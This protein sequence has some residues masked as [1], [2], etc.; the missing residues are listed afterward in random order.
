M[1]TSDKL[2]IY[3]KYDGNIDMFARVGYKRH[4]N[5]I[6]DKEWYIIDELVSRVSNIKSGSASEHYI[7]E[8]DKK[9]KDNLDCEE[10]VKRLKAYCDPEAKKKPW[11]KIW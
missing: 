7:N 2:N 1:I 4:P 6:E 11:W 5:V 9:I 8:T 10:T 3:I